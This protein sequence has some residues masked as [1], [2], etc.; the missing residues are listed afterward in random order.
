MLARSL[1]RGSINKFCSEIRL[2][3][4]HHFDPQVMKHKTSFIPQ[5]IAFL[6]GI[7]DFIRQ[8]HKRSSKRKSDKRDFSI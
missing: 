8:H 3:S 5:A 4:F 6:S 7:A 2:S 1:I